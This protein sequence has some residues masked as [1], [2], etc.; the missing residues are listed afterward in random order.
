[1]Q[2]ALGLEPRIGQG[3]LRN[4]QGEATGEVFMVSNSAAYKPNC[5]SWFVSKRGCDE[6]INF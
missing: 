2:T 4:V 1:M 6:Y 5:A 3:G